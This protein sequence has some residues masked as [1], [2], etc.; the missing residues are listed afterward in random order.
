MALTLNPSPEGRGTLSWIFRW[1]LGG[2]DRGFFG[3]GDAFVG[4]GDVEVGAGRSDLVEVGA[5]GSVEVKAFFVGGMG[6][7][8][9]EDVADRFFPTMDSFDFDQ[10]GVGK[11]VDRSPRGG[12]FG[13]SAE[14]GLKSIA[15]Q[16]FGLL[17]TMDL[18]PVGK[19]IEVLEFGD[20][21]GKG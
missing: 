6:F 10:F 13:A 9:D 15:D 2:C 7:A 14:G 11:K 8:F 18:A 16:S 3:F 4:D 17:A 21:G 12:R 19:E 1:I 20:G 5:V